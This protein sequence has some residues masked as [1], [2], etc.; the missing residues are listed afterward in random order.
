MG[1]SRK[2]RSSRARFEY[3]LEVLGKSFEGRSMIASF[4]SNLQT[5][6][7]HLRAKAATSVIVHPRKRELRTS[8]DLIGPHY[9]GKQSA[10]I[11]GEAWICN[12]V[13]PG[14]FVK[15]KPTSLI[16]INTSNS[17][18]P[19]AWVMLLA[20][21]IVSTQMPFFALLVKSRKQQTIPFPKKN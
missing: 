11:Y 2:L 4:A 1:T 14:S 5:F 17:H 21:G 16:G 19:P 3:C 20:T 18:G 6:V 15:S 9:L 7:V 13:L 8:W 12:R 10:F